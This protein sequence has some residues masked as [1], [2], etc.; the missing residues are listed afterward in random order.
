MILALAVPGL[1]ALALVL[2][3]PVGYVPVLL[4]LLALMVGAVFN[5]RR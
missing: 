3:D 1:L 2:G 5:K 4:S